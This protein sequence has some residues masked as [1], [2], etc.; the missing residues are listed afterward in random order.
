MGQKK[1]GACERHRS[2]GER[3]HEMIEQRDTYGHVF[4]VCKHCG[5]LPVGE[6]IEYD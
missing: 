1:V 2:T 3:K 5:M 6:S 4:E